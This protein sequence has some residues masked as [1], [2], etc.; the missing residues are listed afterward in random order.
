MLKLD[1]TRALE[2]MRTMGFGVRWI[3]WVCGP[4][5]TA[6]PRVMVNGYPGRPIY[7]A[8]G[9][10]QGVPLSPMLFILAMEPLHKMFQLVA[11][12]ALLTP[13]AKAGMQQRL[14]LFGD[15]VMLFIK[16]NEADLRTNAWIF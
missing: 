14:S 3:E 8:R 7:N 4:L 2:V 9:M 16:V 6:S 11:S 15:D 10:R 12:C 5:A 13:L 1:I